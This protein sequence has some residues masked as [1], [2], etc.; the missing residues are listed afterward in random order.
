MRNNDN[1]IKIVDGNINGSVRQSWKIYSDFAFTGWP[2]NILKNK[3]AGQWVC[4]NPGYLREPKW[5]SPCTC[6]WEQKKKLSGMNYHSPRWRC[7]SGTI[8][9]TMLS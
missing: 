1:A 5:C 9:T 8:G 2:E 7:K 6:K 3:K 4:K